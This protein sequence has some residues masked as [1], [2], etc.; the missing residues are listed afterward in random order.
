MDILKTQG[1]SEYAHD[2][3]ISIDS[4]ISVFF[5]PG[6]GIQIELERFNVDLWCF[7]ISD[8]ILQRP[9][10]GIYST[11]L[12]SHTD[13]NKKHYCLIIH[14]SAFGKMFLCE[15]QVW[16]YDNFETLFLPYTIN[17]SS[18]C[19]CS[20]YNFVFIPNFVPLVIRFN[21]IYT[22]DKKFCIFFNTSFSPIAFHFFLKFIIT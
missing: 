18:D 9:R 20:R 1:I 10:R 8:N 14:H 2:F 17:F 7:Q 19:I 22:C 12:L 15:V 3:D 16:C 21:N 4:L 11:N 13:V 5:N 6:A